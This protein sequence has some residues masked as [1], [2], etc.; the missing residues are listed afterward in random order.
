MIPVFP[1]DP[2]RRNFDEIEFFLFFPGPKVSF[3]TLGV[4]LN[5]CVGS[6]GG[7]LLGKKRWGYASS[8]FKVILVWR[9]S[10]QSPRPIELARPWDC[11]NV[12]LLLLASFVK[13]RARGPS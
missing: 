8:S 4:P 12:S 13:K 3:N 11:F 10:A 5:V 9:R 1:R 7:V 2:R 6:D